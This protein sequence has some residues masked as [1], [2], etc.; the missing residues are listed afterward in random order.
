MKRWMG[1]AAVLLVAAQLGGCATPIEKSETTPRLYAVPEPNIALAVIEARPY[2]L[3]G[4]KQPW[5]EGHVRGVFGIPHAIRRPKRPEN[6]RFVDYFAELVKE[7]LAQSGMNPTVVA[8]PNGASLDDAQK[9]LSAS[10]AGRYVVIRVVESNWDLGSV[11][12]NSYKYHFDMN[13]ARPGGS[14]SGKIF[15]AN[16]ANKPSDKYNVFDMHTLRYRNVIETMFN[17]PAIRQA[18]Q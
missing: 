12:L 2:V 3:A 1:V 10:N 16:E 4:S 18:L 14:W 15:S 5:F 13:V 7:G 6:E 11:N 9:K 8:V 17:D